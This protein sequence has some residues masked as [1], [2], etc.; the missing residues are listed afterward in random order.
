MLFIYIYECIHYITSPAELRSGL[1]IVPG[2]LSHVTASNFCDNLLKIDII[3]IA[4]R[5]AV[6]AYI[7]REISKCQTLFETL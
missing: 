3:T 7:Y 1:G 4:F 2:P 5:E 6:I